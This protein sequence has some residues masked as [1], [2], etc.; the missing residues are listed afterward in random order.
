[1]LPD[2]DVLG[3]MFRDGEICLFCLGLSFA[4]DVG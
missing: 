1:M 2:A 3:W 4:L